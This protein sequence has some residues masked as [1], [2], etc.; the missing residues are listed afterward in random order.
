M[1]II[2]V[3]CGLRGEYESDLRSNYYHLNSTE[4]KARK[5]IQACAGFQPTTSAILV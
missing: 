1:K 4:D 2:Y 3:G 5:K